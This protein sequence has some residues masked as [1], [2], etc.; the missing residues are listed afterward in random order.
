MIAVGVDTHKQ[1]HY[2]VALDH[3]GQLLAELSFA[4]SAAGYAELQHW[5]ERLVE[6]RALVFGLEVPA[7]GARA[8]A[9]T[10]ST[11]A[12]RSSRWSVPGERTGE[13]ASQTGSMRSPLRSAC[14]AASTSRR[15][16]AAGSSPRSG[17]C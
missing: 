10:F 1:R 11:P 5:A 4:A 17:R 15:H 9:S 13:P 16:A 14:S 6:D 7:A 3:V 2:A 8:Y 12:T